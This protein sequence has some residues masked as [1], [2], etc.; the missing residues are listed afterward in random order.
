MKFLPP[1]RR[2]C[3]YGLI[4][5]ALGGT[6]GMAVAAELERVDDATDFQSVETNIEKLKQDM[7]K[8][9]C[10]AWDFEQHLKPVG[11]AGIIKVTGLPGREGIVFSGPTNV[12]SS[13]NIPLSILKSGL[14]MRN[15]QGG[16][17]NN[18]FQFPEDTEGKTTACKVKEPAQDNCAKKFPYKHDPYTDGETSCVTNPDLAPSP[19]NG[20]SEEKCEKICKELNLW[21]KDVIVVISSNK[22]VW[23]AQKCRRKD[24]AAEEKPPAYSTF[25]ECT[26][27]GENVCETKP[28]FCCTLANLEDTDN[29]NCLKCQGEDCRFGKKAKP[30]G[31]QYVSF[32]RKFTGSFM[33]AKVE[34]NPNQDVNQMSNLIVKCYARLNDP[35]NL[36]TSE[37]DPKIKRTIAPD[38]H[39]VLDLEGS[40]NL[41]IFQKMKETQKGK[42]KKWGQDSSFSDPSYSSSSRAALDDLWVT[43]MSNAFSML[44]GEKQ[45]EQF[46]DAPLTLLSLDST[47][48]IPTAQMT[49][50]LVFSSGSLMRAFDDTVSIQ[51][52]NGPAAVAALA[53]GV[54][55]ARPGRRTITE[56][57]Q[58][59]E[60]EMNKLFTPPILRVLL[61]TPASEDLVFDHPLLNPA[62]T[63]KDNPKPKDHL[64]P[65]TKAI[66]IQLRATPDDLAGEVSS[67]LS[68]SLL[69]RIEEE[70]IPIVVPLAS[71]VELRALA[72][73][74][75]SWGKERDALDEDSNGADEIANKLEKYANKA[76]EVR[77]LRGEL[78]QYVGKL[79]KFQKD[80]MSSITD[81]HK[82]N[83]AALD[84][85]N[86]KWQERIALKSTWEE[87]QQLYRK[88]TDDSA[89]PW[90]RND[91]FSTPVYSLL[92]YW[93]PKNQSPRD[94]ALDIDG[95]PS[96]SDLDDHLPR[97]KVDV[98]PDLVYDF[99]ALRVA[100]GA[101][102]LPVLKPLQI[103]LDLH[104]LQPP[105]FNQSAASISEQM[106]YIK[107][108]PG[109]F[110]N[111]PT[112]FKEVTEK[113]LPSEVIKIK[114]PDF[115]SESLPSPDPRIE[116]TMSKMKEMLQ[117]MDKTH[118]D[119][120]ESLT[121][122]L[123]SDINKWNCVNIDSA[124][125]IH[126]EMDLLERFG[127]IGARP[128][129]FLYEDF[130]SIGSWRSSSSSPTAGGA[131]GTSFPVPDPIKT[132]P[133]CP[134]ADWSCQ[135]INAE[136]TLPRSGWRAEGMKDEEQ[137]KA[138][139]DLRKRMRDETIPKNDA[140]AFPYAAS[141]N[142]LLPGLASPAPLIIGVPL[143]SYSSASHSPSSP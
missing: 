16:N 65:G 28:V 3:P 117:G 130:L 106:A 73:G 53:T 140:N 96:E 119:F 32:F 64:P 34:K 74:W 83:V 142:D 54:T 58:E 124:P 33:R 129:V 113:V 68:D 87:I 47:S 1:L 131:P 29:S 69:L 70:P 35:S 115:L 4:A 91:R 15:E 42:G 95:Q 122:D 19:P 52:P 46:K 81:W 40:P 26:V 2:L 63:S 23:K 134:R 38:R 137:K 49:K 78:L 51:N 126:V 84:Q 25:P 108:L 55:Y 102:K 44:N 97:I 86:S 45:K 105:S 67:Y 41:N 111:V 123:S 116:I 48:L 11:G 89:F 61:P 71:P 118:K 21:V 110:P 112:I 56:W 82:N 133:S 141:P 85:Y 60:T 57:W 72:Q 139:Q 14:A 132:S 22:I 27:N 143:S 62:V 7:E 43:D 12:P 77:A 101:V 100:S 5:L 6:I 88:F 127:R 109:E 76:D 79:L 75:R 120:W 107:N 128:A 90:C 13:T 36:P 37:F 50:D 39:C 121:K 8:A 31:R 125:C 103:R 80:M 135:I 18:G 66:D 17:L 24:C 104:R 9:M 20:S 94:L 92:D 99:T 136:K 114:P 138:L 10:G 59:Q 30:N 98:M 93:M